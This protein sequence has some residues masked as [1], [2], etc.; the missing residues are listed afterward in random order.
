MTT[1]EWKYGE[2]PLKVKRPEKTFSFP[3][4]EQQAGGDGINFGDTLDLNVGDVEL[5]TGLLLQYLKLCYLLAA[6]AI[7]KLS[8]LQVKLIGEI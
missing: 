8:F 2:P 5:E 4:D 3:E 6:K 1:Y 7:F